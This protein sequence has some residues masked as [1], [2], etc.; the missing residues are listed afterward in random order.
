M[1][2]VALLGSDPPDLIAKFGNVTV[3]KPGDWVPILPG[4]I[5]DSVSEIF[6]P[7]G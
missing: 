7:R 1:T 6:R 5:D 2:K 3:E 4:D